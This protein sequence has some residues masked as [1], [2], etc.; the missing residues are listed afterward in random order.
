[1]LQQARITL[2]A[3]DPRDACRRAAS[4]ADQRWVEFFFL[5]LQPASRVLK[6]P[7][8]RGTNRPM[9][10]RLSRLIKTIESSC[11]A[12]NI[13]HLKKVKHALPISARTFVSS[14]LTQKT[15]LKSHFRG[16]TNDCDVFGDPRSGVPAM[17]RYSQDAL[18][19]VS[20]AG[21]AVLLDIRRGL[22]F[23]R[24]MKRSRRT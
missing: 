14:R 5:G 19:Q 24:A 4:R 7:F 12:A 16:W 2:F 8:Y 10:C 1:M 21:E 17:A 6:T 15:G 22:H 9:R 18:V 23:C 11:C 3:A 13:F 20:S